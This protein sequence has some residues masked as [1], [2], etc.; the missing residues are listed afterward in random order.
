VSI[1]LFDQYIY[2]IQISGHRAEPTVSAAIE[3]DFIF[4]NGRRFNDHGCGTYD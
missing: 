4:G 1:P 3:H 2:G